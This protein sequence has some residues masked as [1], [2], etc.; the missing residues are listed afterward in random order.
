M[1]SLA[2]MRSV[3]PAGDSM[4]PLGPPIRP[5]QGVAIPLPKPTGTPG[6]VQLPDGKLATNLPLPPAKPAVKADDTVYAEIAAEYFHGTTTGRFRSDKANLSN[7]PKPA[8]REPKVD[9]WVRILSGQDGIEDIN[10]MVGGIFQVNEVLKAS[11][12]TMSII[13]NSWYFRAPGSTS[14]D[15][16][17][18]TEFAEPP[19]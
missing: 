12:G 16:S 5:Q 8:K 18:L 11:D 4:Q 17:L 2:S 14:P 13:V 6:V 3:D 1:P 19:L 7:E 15:G 9:N 10:E